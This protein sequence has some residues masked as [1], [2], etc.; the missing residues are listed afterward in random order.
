MRN[1]VTKVS[2]LAAIVA[3][4]ACSSFAGAVLTLSDG[5]N[6]V[7]VNATGGFASYNGS[8]GG[9]SINVTTGI[10]GGTSTQP[11]LDLNSVDMY[12]GTGPGKL[13]I[14]WTQDGLGPLLGTGVNEV[15]GTLLPGISGNFQMFVNG[16]SVSSQDFSSSPFAGTASADLGGA[17]GTLGLQATLTAT[18]HGLISFDSQACVSSVPDG[19]TTIALLG[20][21]LVGV[22]GL[23]RRLMC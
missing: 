8:V 12:S 3:G 20:F 15:G 13:I 22:E 2:V 1:V 21:A 10:A 4:C 14:T 18:S 17:T 23:R 5:I 7:T 9:W 19:G 11:I 6:S 16:Q